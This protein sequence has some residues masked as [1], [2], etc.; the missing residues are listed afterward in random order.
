M[1]AIALVFWPDDYTEVHVRGQDVSSFGALGVHLEF[2]AAA[3]ACEDVVAAPPYD[4]FRPSKFVPPACVM[5]H[6]C[7]ASEQLKAEEGIGRWRRFPPM[8]AGAPPRTAV[9]PEEHH[10]DDG[11]RA[12]QLYSRAGAG[13]ALLQREDLEGPLAGMMWGVA[14]CWVTA[15]WQ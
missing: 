1:V 12:G 7:F 8:S 13:I 5:V 6:A 4:G 10:I 15:L 3:F 14:P 2:P 9:A 11:C